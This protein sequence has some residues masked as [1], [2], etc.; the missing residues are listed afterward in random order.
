MFG[1]IGTLAEELALWTTLNCQ[2]FEP[3]FV[4]HVLSS[5]RYVN[6]L[7]S[8]S[9]YVAGIRYYELY[10]LLFGVG[11]SIDAVVN[12]VLRAVVAD[13]TLASPLCVD[14][15]SAA[16]GNWPSFQSEQAA[17]V[18]V[19]LASYA[20]VYRARPHVLSNLLLMLFYSAVVAG[21]LLLNYHTR[22][23]I[24]GATIVGS[25]VAFVWQLALRWAV[26]PEV[27]DLLALWPLRYFEYRETLCRDTSASRHDD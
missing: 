1:A 8:L 7:L 24:L 12:L 13:S 11:T 18:T 16:G 5:L 10:L 6:A 26:L 9:L 17:F 22:S 14:A 25:V 4:A 3:T 19:F 15:Y 2:P 27:D 20:V 23:Q 21:E